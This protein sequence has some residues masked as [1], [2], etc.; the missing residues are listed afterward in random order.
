MTKEISNET[1]SQINIGGFNGSRSLMPNTIDEAYRIAQAFSRSDFIPKEYRGQPDNCFTA[2]NLGMEIGLPPM[3]ALQS[4]AVVNGKPTIYGDAQL[5]LVR[6]SGILETFEESYEGQ[7]GT[8]SFAAICKI[9]RKG[10]SETTIEKFTVADAKKAG[11]WG[12]SGPWTTH[13]K[14]MMRYKARAFAL[15]DKF[16]D[17]LLG[18]THSV[19]EMQGEQMIDATP[20]SKTAAA[21]TPP[22][23]IE[24]SFKL[25]DQKPKFTE[26]VK[27]TA[28][29]D[30]IEQTEEQII[31]D[32][33]DVAE[34]AFKRVSDGLNSMTTEK[35]INAFFDRSAKED[36]D[37]LKQN[38]PDYYAELASLKAKRLEELK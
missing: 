25:P 9:K 32:S 18:L 33:D 6:G 24:Q 37:Y 3:R 19:E 4:I 1:K 5:A 29:E 36:L 8:D 28:I 35:G 26:E 15:R 21:H 20:K 14:R 13:P 30:Y 11:L 38:R 23:A 17:V 16:A 27:Q 34:G 7:E 2:I 10:D 12:K 31:T 22:A